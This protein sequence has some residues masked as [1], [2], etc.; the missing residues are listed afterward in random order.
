MEQTVREL[1]K[2]FTSLSSETQHI[3]GHWEHEG[4]IFAD[5][6]VRLFIDVLDT[7]KNRQFFVA[8]KELLK[9]RFQQ[10]DIWMTPYLVEVI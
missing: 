7:P 2:Q 9:E 8:Y 4:T 6:N 1:R 10:I 3:E 5:L